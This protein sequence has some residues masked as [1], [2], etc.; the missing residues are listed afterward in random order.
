M[1]HMLNTELPDDR[2]TDSGVFDMALTAETHSCLQSGSCRTDPKLTDKPTVWAHPTLLS[3]IRE[4]MSAC[5]K[6][7]EHNYNSMS[8]RPE[9]S[10]VSVV[11]FY[12]VVVRM[13]C[14][15]SHQHTSEAVI[16]TLQSLLQ[17]RLRNICGQFERGMLLVNTAVKT[18]WPKTEDNKPPSRETNG[19]SFHFQTS[20]CS[21]LLPDKD[22]ISGNNLNALHLITASVCLKRVVF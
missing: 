9:N 3:P 13:L 8:V 17:V 12:H 7:L 5:S 15:K 10:T 19:V 14:C 21:S 16:H 4:P 6:C 11:F 20:L 18:K 1:L 2:V 22:L